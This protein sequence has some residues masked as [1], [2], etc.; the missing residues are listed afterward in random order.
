MT[1]AGKRERYLTPCKT[2]RCFGRKT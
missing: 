2:V 1:S